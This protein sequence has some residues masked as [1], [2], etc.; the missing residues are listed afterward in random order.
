MARVVGEVAIDVTADIGPLM[1][2]GNRGAGALDGLRGAANKAGRGL[3][4]L[5]DITTN[6]GK[7]L[8]VISAA[9]GAVAGAG[10]LLAKSTADNAREI[11][12]LARVANTGTTEFQRMAAGAKTVGIEQDKLA[13]IL[14]DV[15]DRVGDFNATGGGPMADFF[16]NIAPKV[17]ITADAFKDLSGPQAL[18]LYVDS[19]NKAGL[20]QADMTF[21]MEAMASDATALLPLL[22]DNGKEMTRLGDAAAKAGG[23][24]STTAIAKSQQFQEALGRLQGGIEG[25]KNK[26][27]V[28]LMPALTNLMNTISDK[29]IP[30][31]N[32]LVDVI[33]GWIDQFANLPSGVQEAALAVASVF[34]VGGPML[35]AIGVASGVI[36]AFVAT[37]GP[38]GLLV[39]AASLLAAAWVAWGDDF[40]AAVGGAIDWVSGKFDA[41]LA[42]MQGVVDKAV[43]VGSAIANAVAPG[44][45]MGAGGT[46]KGFGA[47]PDLGEGFGMGQQLGNG[48]VSGLG[49]SITDNEEKMRAVIDRVPAI[50]R[51]QLGIQSPSRVFAE[52]GNFLGMGMAQGISES[53]GLVADA[54]ANMGRVAVDQADA[55]AGAVLQ[56]MGQLFQGSKKLSAGIALANSWL[57]FTEVLKDPSFIG[58]PFARIA[59]AGSALASGLNAVRNIKSAQ[60]GGASAGSASSAS[61]APSIPQSIANITLNGDTFSRGTVEGLFEQINDG[62]RQG[63]VINLVRA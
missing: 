38:I 32:K 55:S 61:A 31:V 54:A 56:S 28:A 21:Y 18:Q 34:A 46:V 3:Q 51:D 24:L 44:V 40:K 17:G 43:A 57:A 35:V 25:V 59:A 60:P 41:L 7:K 52:I 5:G 11:Q 42:T 49:Q 19:L 53:T 37:L 39:T 30:V 33:G 27:A 23:I 48:M 15:N 47:Q 26:L 22:A 50:A 14:K 45:S 4:R 29:V 2:A 10:F 16:E 6:L 13:D 9:M 1:K 8:S 62:L 36:R 63:R 12:N 58:R 20:S